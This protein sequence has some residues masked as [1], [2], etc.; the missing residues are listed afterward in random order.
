MGSLSCWFPL[1]VTIFFAVALICAA[2]FYAYMEF[3]K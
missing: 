1:A 3:K 2:T